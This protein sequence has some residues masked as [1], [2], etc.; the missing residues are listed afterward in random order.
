MCTAV[1]YLPAW[2]EGAREELNLK[3]VLKKYRNV[4]RT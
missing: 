4:E 2:S 3:N 1:Y